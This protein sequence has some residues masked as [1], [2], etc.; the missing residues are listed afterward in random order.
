MREG[1]N[2]N[3]LLQGERIHTCGVKIGYPGLGLEPSVFG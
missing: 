1:K 2:V 3:C